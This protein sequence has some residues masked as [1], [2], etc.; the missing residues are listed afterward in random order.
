MI[1]RCLAVM[2]LFFSL[3]SLAFA[4]NEGDAKQL[5]QDWFTAMK[6][7]EVDKAADFLAPQF[8][9][10]HTDG[11]VRNKAQE[12]SLMKDLHMQTFNLTQFKTTESG[13]IMIVTFKDEGAETIDKM[14]IGTQ[15]AGRMAVLQNQNGKWLIVG[16]ANLD[17]IG[18]KK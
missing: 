15:P 16:Y 12:V 18:S 5:I 13:D 2:T 8:V 9:S 17:S 4:N 14:P 3:T 11:T 1:K 10:I 6:N 7:N